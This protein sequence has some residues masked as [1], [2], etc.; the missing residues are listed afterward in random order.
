MS[1]ELKNIEENVMEQ[2][3]LGK[4]KMKPK[5]YFILGSIL[6]FAGLI[7][8]IIVSVFMVGLIRFSLRTHYGP[9][10][11]YRL[12]RMLA[13]FPWWIIPITVIGLMVGILIIKKYNFIY[14]IKSWILVLGFILAVIFT[15]LII[16]KIGV[17]DIL[18]KGNHMKRMMRIHIDQDISERGTNWKR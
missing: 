7:S 6:V 13:E 18:L 14:K 10:A 12:E 15:G 17:N 8:A 9:G 3:H 11:G 16:D 1:K 5:L 2:I 4:I